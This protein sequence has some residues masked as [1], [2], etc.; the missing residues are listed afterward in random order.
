MY[1]YTYVEL[2]QTVPNLSLCFT[3]TFI[4][5]SSIQR[6]TRPAPVGGH[7]LA[8]PVVFLKSFALLGCL[9]MS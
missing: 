5:S 6:M 7:R 2:G 4:C 8:L 1:I 9:R 3:Y